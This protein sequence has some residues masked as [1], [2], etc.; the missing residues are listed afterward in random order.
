[1]SIYSKHYQNN[2]VQLWHTFVQRGTPLDENAENSMRKVIYES[3]QRSKQYKVNPLEVKSKVLSS[4]E[5]QQKIIQKQSLIEVAHSYMH[6]LYSFVKGSN[7]VVI[8]TDEEGY[9]LEMIGDDEFIKERTRTSNLVLGSNR[10]EEYAGTNAIGTPLVINAPLQVWGEEHY[11][12]PHHPFTCSGAP[13][14]DQKGYII[15]C[16]DI[17]GPR[18]KIHHHTLGMVV[19]AVD[20]I[21]KE[22]K[23]RKAYEDISIINN[24]LTGTIQSISSGIIMIDNIGIITQFNNHA[25]KMFKLNVKEL[26]G[27][28]LYDIIDCQA[29]PID[30]LSINKNIYD[31]EVHLTN[32]Y[33]QPLDLSVSVSIIPNNHGNRIGA[34]IVI[35]E[36]QHIHK[37]VN[38]FGG[39][40]A[41]Y[42]FDSIIGKSQDIEEVKKLGAIAANSSSNVLIFGESGTGKELIAQ[43][44][45]SSSNR[46]KGPFI[47]I[48]CGSLP[49]GLIESELFGYEGGA[50]TGANKEGHPG[51]FEL[52]DGGTI[53]LDEI[54]DMP[55]DLQ[56]SLLRVLQS[57]E[58]VRIGGKKPKQIDVRIMAATNKNLEDNI[59]QNSFRSD[60]YYRLNVFS[61]F[62]PPL[63]NRKEDLSVLCEYFIQSCN[64]KLRKNIKGISDEAFSL[65]AS[66]NWP[67]NIREL[68]NVIERAVNL[69]GSD[70]IQPENLP[71]NI[72]HKQ[73]RTNVST[74][75]NQ[76]KFQAAS[77]NNP[78]SADKPFDSSVSSIKHVEYTAIIEALT[79]TSGNMQ[80]S[81]D[82]LGIGR[83]T[84]YRKISKY[85][86]DPCKFR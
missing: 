83:R 19:A 85:S 17:T 3:W 50:F 43:A 32:L 81:A 13:I 61:I 68:E 24:Q 48:N 47:A 18:E 46:S 62:V 33:H 21:E 41:K 73:N 38:K 60:L 82:L 42:T 15:G 78:Y 25:A 28:N 6:N 5:F 66:Y 45:H 53:F 40:N 27:K 63:R 65:L 7:F 16:M 52:A 31:K 20:A 39:F 8:L 23:M 14:H 67:G 37:L 64:I 1:M 86:I 71:H 69:A 58:I 75:A 84:L 56:A 74:A 34:V 59:M 10:S 9:I 79:K 26:L 51:K 44:I 35:N 49:K 29:C 57:K 72:V 22:M 2:I 54:G 12:K 80:K 30:F 4:K 76:N 55:L 36:I 11:V 70:N 77:F